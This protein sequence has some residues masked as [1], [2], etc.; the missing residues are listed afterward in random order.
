[1]PVEQKLEVVLAV[2]RGGLSV[3]EAA[4]RYPV[5]PGTVHRWKQNF[6]K[7]FSGTYIRMGYRSPEQI[8]VIERYHQNLKQEAIYPGEVQNILHLMKSVEH[9]TWYPGSRRPHW[10][11]GLRTPAEV[12]LNKSF[13][14][15]RRLSF[16]SGVTGYKISIQ[17]MHA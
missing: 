7:T 14:E 5:S 16:D 3:E 6:L 11:S 1:M 8:G 4:G 12:Y 10:A 17:E 9:Y 13:H 2:S 15:I